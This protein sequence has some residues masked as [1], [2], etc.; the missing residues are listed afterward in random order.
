MKIGVLGS[1]I[2]GQTLAAG[3]LRHGHAAMIGTRQPDHE[4]MKKWLAENPSGSVS[5]FEQA[6]RF[7][8]LLVLASLGR[9]A[10]QVIELAGK[11]NFDGKALIDTTNPIAETPP[12]EGVLQFFTGPDQSLGEQIQAQLPAAHVVKA[13]NSVGAARMVNPHFD[14]GTPTMF[15]CGDDAGAKAAVSGLIRELG[16]EAFDCG[17]IVAARALE[18]L[19]VLWC[20]PGFVHNQWTHAFKLLQR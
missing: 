4:A 14:E 7:G 18:P 19:C 16:W 17:G 3:F 5:S 2:V 20:I 8:E 6:A 9:A 1:G 13:F 10:S 11:A 15:L 12:V